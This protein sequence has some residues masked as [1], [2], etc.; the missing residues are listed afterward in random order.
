MMDHIL[1]S[2][3]LL[4]G[5]TARLK[6]VESPTIPDAVQRAL[7]RHPTEFSGLGALERCWLLQV[8]DA[9][10]A[11]VLIYPEGAV[12]W[13][14]YAILSRE[15]IQF[16]SSKSKVA[17]LAGGFGEGMKVWVPGGVHADAAE[18]WEFGPM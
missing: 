11:A 7:P 17:G 5:E 1:E 13:Q 8:D 14:K 6:A 18:V 12:L 3:G 2:W 15:H 10:A 16:R 9:L 4:P